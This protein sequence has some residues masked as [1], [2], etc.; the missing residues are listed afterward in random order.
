MFA[1]A[2][3]GGRSSHNSSCRAS[4]TCHAHSSPSRPGWTERDAA[5]RPAQS[6]A[7]G[8]PMIREPRSR[9]AVSSS[10]PLVRAA[11]SPRCRIEPIP[12]AQ[13][14]PVGAPMPGVH[15]R[16]AAS[17]RTKTAYPPS[18]N[19]SSISAAAGLSAVIQIWWASRQTMIASSCL[20]T[21]DNCFP[22]SILSRTSR[23]VA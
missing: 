2:D 23:S 18:P 21:V 16:P 19:S 12:D 10:K 8:A 17:C 15:P 22:N 4:G 1:A 9:D 3:A 6:T 20:P 11:V 14:R 13:R 5:R 7:N